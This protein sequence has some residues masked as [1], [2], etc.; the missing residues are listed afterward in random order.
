M[1]WIEILSVVGGFELIRYVVDA[2]RHHK[3]DKKK[4]EIEVSKNQV[5]VMNLDF[6]KD[7]QQVE[8]YEMRLAQR[9]DKIDELYKELRLEQERRMEEVK[10]RH[11]LELRVKE[12]EVRRCDVRGCALRKPP[13]EY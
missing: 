10:S 13:S 6:E 8:W 5:E 3:T 4:R 12:M 1:G 9:N 2:V 11:D 7:K